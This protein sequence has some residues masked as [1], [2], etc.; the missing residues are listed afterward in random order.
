M[1]YVINKFISK[2][3]ICF[4]V[5]VKESISTVS[6]ERLLS[7]NVSKFSICEEEQDWFEIDSEGEVELFS[8]TISPVKMVCK[9]NYKALSEDEEAPLNDLGEKSKIVN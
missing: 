7:P 8:K 2:L 1:K 9:K 5:K 6:A 3:T 4:G